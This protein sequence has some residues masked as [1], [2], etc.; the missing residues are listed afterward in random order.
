M[1]VR[2]L[3]LQGRGIHGYPGESGD[4][5]LGYGLAAPYRGN[6][7]GT[8]VVIALSQWLLSRAGVRRAVARRVRK[9]NL[10]SRRALA[11]A[12]FELEFADDEYTSYALTPGRIPT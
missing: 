2:G 4:I 5:E 10:P 1:R 9:H 7:Y 11:R 3:E 8:E 6:G 12:G